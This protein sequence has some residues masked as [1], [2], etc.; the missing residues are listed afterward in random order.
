MLSFLQTIGLTENEA[1]IYEILLKLGEVPVREI[2]KKTK[3]KRPAVYKTLYTLEE[4]GLATH[5]EFK[6]IIHFKV[7][8]PTQ[9]IELADEEYKKIERARKDLQST[10]PQLS[11]QYIFNVDKPIVK[12]YE[13]LQGLKEIY[14]D[15][16][17]EAKPGFSFLQTEDMEPE[18]LKWLRIYFLKGRL[19]R[20]MHLKAIVSTGKHAKSFVSRD[21]DEYRI[22]KT[23][24]SHLFPFQHEVTIYGDKVAFVHYKKGESLIGM[25]VKHPQFAQTMKAIFDLAWHGAQHLS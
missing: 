21:I 1:E 8:S 13:G 7:E 10:L 19:K 14:L 24:P 2:T 12:L 23:I 9:L 5:K 25:V 16:L 4:K 17:K 6:K 20:K 15:I 18:L 3:L 22:S 11:S